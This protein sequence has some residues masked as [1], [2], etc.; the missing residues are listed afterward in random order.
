[1][2]CVVRWARLKNATKPFSLAE[3][4]LTETVVCW[5]DYATVEAAQAQMEQRCST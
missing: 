1:M 2:L 5:R 4:S 3:V